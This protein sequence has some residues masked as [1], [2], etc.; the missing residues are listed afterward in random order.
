M[1]LSVSQPLTLTPVSLL[2][3]TASSME[4]CWSCS[5][6]LHLL[7]TLSRGNLTSTPAPW[8]TLLL[9]ESS[10]TFLLLNS[11]ETLCLLEI[12]TF[13]TVIHS[14][15]F[16]CSLFHNSLNPSYLV[17]FPSAS[18]IQLESSWSVL[19][20]QIPLGQ[21]NHPCHS[22]HIQQWW[23]CWLAPQPL[24]TWRVQNRISLCPAREPPPLSKFPIL[25]MVPLSVPLVSREKARHHLT[26][27]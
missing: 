19:P 12:H 15:L 20:L 4:S 18:M 2:V 10:V 26:S 9:P 27:S 23:I 3:L 6:L 25:A 17:F 5:P 22:S 8:L 13:H 7:H 24:Q 14:S 21:F 16:Q 1:Y 11:T